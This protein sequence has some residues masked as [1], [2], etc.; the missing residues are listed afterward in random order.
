KYGGH[1]LLVQFLDG[2]PV[3]MQFAGDIR[4]RAAPAA[5]AHVPGK[6]LGV[7]RIV[8]QE[9]EPFAL[10]F[11]AVPAKHPSDP[12]FQI[13]AR[14]PAGQVANPS[15]LLVVPA[16]MRQPATVADGFFERRTS[17]MTR[18]LG[19]PKMPRI[20]SSGRKW[21]NRYA[22]SRRLRLGEMAIGK[23]SRFLQRV[24]TGFCQMPQGLQRISC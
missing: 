7:E 1:V 8:R 11:S 5:P 24:Q 6:P 14:I 15:Q 12:D 10:H 2:V 20:F 9:V 22:S 23:S 21:A 17:V 4:N 19:S 18:A 3:Q 13:D 16:R